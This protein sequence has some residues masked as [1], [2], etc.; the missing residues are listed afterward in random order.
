MKNVLVRVCFCLPAARTRQTFALSLFFF[1]PPLLRRYLPAP[2]YGTVSWTD[3][4]SRQDAYHRAFG[5]NNGSS[6]GIRNSP[7]SN[8]KPT[9]YQSPTHISNDPSGIIA[10][11]AL[12]LSRTQRRIHSGK[13]QTKIPIRASAS[14]SQK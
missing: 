11:I 1:P 13:V 9:N 10:W 4:L 12:S 14:K 2:Q 8:K 7:A 6:S 3:L 5:S